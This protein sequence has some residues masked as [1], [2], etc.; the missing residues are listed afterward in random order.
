[1]N[2]VTLKQLLF[3]KCKFG[4]RSIGRLLLRWKDHHKSNVKHAHIYASTWQMISLERAS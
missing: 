2:T 1:M 4:A 3:G